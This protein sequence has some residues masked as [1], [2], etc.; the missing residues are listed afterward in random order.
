MCVRALQR[1]ECVTRPLRE[2][3]ALGPAQPGANPAHTLCCGRG[4]KRASWDIPE[5]GVAAAR[6][7]SPSV[8][9]EPGW[10]QGLWGREFLEKEMVVVRQ[11]DGATSLGDL[12]GKPLAPGA[13]SWWDVGQARG[14]GPSSSPPESTWCS[15]SAE[16]GQ[17]QV[18]ADGAW[19]Q[20][21]AVFGPQNLH[22]PRDV[23]H[24]HPEAAPTTP[25]ASI[26]PLYGTAHGNSR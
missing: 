1:C 26:L 17:Q 21:L 3:L 18:L 8:L 20:P 15:P 25:R 6:Q 10:P 24:G 11:D 7:A 2:G 19:G 14:P 22:F 4:R 9:R 23:S 13:L 12:S 5:S 16:V